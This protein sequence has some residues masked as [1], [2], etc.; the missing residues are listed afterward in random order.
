MKKKYIKIKIPFIKSKKRLDYILS[1]ILFKYS[2]SYIK[3][4]I[5]NKKVKINN[6]IIIKP[7]TN[8]NSYDIIKIFFIIIIN[9]YCLKI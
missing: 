1:K 6:N 7:N 8:I 5:N 3:F 9:I 4:L 2:R